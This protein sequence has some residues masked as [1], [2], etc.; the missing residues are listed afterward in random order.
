MDTAF[1]VIQDPAPGIHLLMFRGDTRTFTL[2]L[3]RAEKGS[4]WLRTNIGHAATAREEIFAEAER[5][6]SPLGRDWFDIPM[7]QVGDRHFEVTVPLCEVGHFEAK[8][9]FLKAGKFTPVWPQG[10]NTAINVEPADTCC[11]N[12]IYNAFVRQF[13][14]N[15]AGGGT[16]DDSQKRC[17]QSL[18]N[19][20]YTVIPKSGTFRD[21]IKELD[22]I[23]GELGCR[24]IQLLPINPTPTTYARM[25]RFGSPFAA[26]SFTAVDPSLAQFDSRAT[27]LEQFIELV[28]AVHERYA[29][30][31]IDI[32]INHT[33]W[34]AGIH[35]MYPEWLVRGSDGRI[36]VP[37]AWGVRWEDLTKLD[38]RHKDLWRYMVDVFLTWCRRGV[39][40]F[41]CDAGYM[42]PVPIW[43]YIVASVR[44]EYPNTIFLLEGL[45]GKI[46]VT[47]TILNQA[48]FNWAYSELF[49]NYD[50]GQIEAYLP[51][52]VA[53]SQADGITVHFAE[54]HDNLRLASRS[55]TYAKMRTALCALCSLQGAFGFANG[56]EWFATEKINV[57]ESPSLNWGATTNQVNEIHRFNKLLKCHPAFHD[58]VALTLVQDG[59]GN[60][61]ALRRLHL[62]SGKK[63]LIVANLDDQNQT[64]G[65]WDSRLAG[66]DG[67]VFKDLLSGADIVTN[68]SDHR[69]TYWLDPGQVLCLTSDSEDL[70]RL[71]RT[72]ELNFNLPERIEKQCLRAKALD[73]FRYCQG[74]RELGEF[75]PDQ[76]AQ[77]L[78]KDPVDYCRMMN[79]VS[80]ESRVIVWHWPRDA[81]REVMVPPGYFLLVRSDVSF[82]A[83][84][85]INNRTQAHEESLRQ[86]DGSFFALFSPLPVPAHDCT[87]TLDLTVYTHKGCEHLQAP[88]L[89]LPPADNAVLTHQFRRS[90]LLRKPLSLLGTNGR[91]GMLRVPVAWGTLNSRYDAILAANL[92][93]EY[94]EDR[95]IMLTRCRTW[96]VY[97]G[98]S[99]DITQGC[100]RSFSFDYN[101]RGIWHFRVPTGQ[102]EHVLFSL[103]VEMA[104]GENAV[105]IIFFRHSDAKEPALLADDKKIRLILRPDI[106]DRNLHDTT[107]AFRGPE[108]HWPA[109]VAVHPD[110]F[111]FAPDPRRRLEVRISKGNFASE[112]EWQYMVY[113]PLEKERGLDPD[114]DLFSPGYFST[115]L[116]GS[117]HV[118]LTAQ[119]S[120]PGR[121]KF[122]AFKSIDPK[123]TLFGVDN[124]IAH[125]PVEAL[126]R[127]IDHYIVKRGTLKSVIAGYP[128][129]LDWGRDSLI[130]VRGLIA[131]RRTEDARAV[132]KQFGRFEKDG[133]LPNMIW[134]QDAGNRDTSDAPLWFFLA[135]SELVRSEG[136]EVFLDEPCNGRTI[137]RILVSMGRSLRAGTPNGIGMDSKSGLIFSPSH[138]TWMDTNHPTGTPRQGFPIEIQALWY[139]ALT[140]LAQ[141]DPA[142]T[143]SRWKK[144]AAQVQASILDL[145][146]LDHEGYLSDCLHADSG[147]SARQAEPDD[148][149][150]PNQLLA[151][152]LGA[153]AETAACRSI[154]TACQELLVPGAIRSLADR[155]VRRPLAIV[156]DGTLL[157]DPHHPYQGSYTGDENTRRKPAYHNGTAWTWMFPSFC[158]AWVRAYGDEGRPA[159][160][161]W[162]ASGIR[163]INQGCVGH[164]PE[165][166][167][168]DFPHTQRGCDAQAWGASELLRVWIQL[169]DQRTVKPPG[170]SAKG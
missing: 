40:G 100:L 163:H 93:P 97:Q 105:R 10:P 50:R 79:P 22:F 109:S 47:R 21:L 46:S 17:I 112:P 61:I 28:D 165:I 95:W 54:T 38:Y 2:T 101:S 57:H 52:A 51:E 91:G 20:G 124:T 88:L 153:V 137:R 102:G 53:I 166:L 149:L 80:P 76:A 27:P 90:E 14:P 141:I 152:T 44:S 89:F 86:A 63:L 12:I 70:E 56:V 154:V 108:H 48:N 125:K 9:F 42:I 34:A 41:R 121:Q 138:F 167:D 136:K 142:K 7:K 164:V 120:K 99:Q 5:D 116:S 13:G 131:A 68:A 104:S 96:L 117:Q 3:S 119:V 106:E 65:S 74:T 49:Q 24:I 156:H 55:T 148:A 43:K 130:V 110:G 98:Y 16:P 150:R 132:L 118:E 111:S 155:P 87:C 162:L 4:A 1:S 169:T 35:E 115:E 113:H 31:F 160:L 135:C 161:A 146:L 123:K 114:S 8:C 134:G 147:V 11:A 122:P 58:Q 37:G 59:G 19:A 85:T 29:K 45:G 158:E 157:N 62:P 36:E 71:N 73:V 159:A 140:F 23:I 83:G 82:R 72:A 139:H 94:P 32:A 127:A 67:N 64:L 170:R 144:L 39:D 77:T 60:H 107:K 126:A 145:F 143:R 33:G 6:E 75:D 66:M 133:T 15:K 30:V 26:L 84:L 81:K 128:W 151:V 25:G 69:H 103:R 92:H 168:G 18:D 78:A 129:F